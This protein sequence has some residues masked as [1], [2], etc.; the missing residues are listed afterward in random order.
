VSGGLDGRCNIKPPN[1]GSMSGR[2]FQVPLREV[3]QLNVMAVIDIS[4]ATFKLVIAC[5]AQ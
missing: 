1:L 3:L 2:K 5:T 4:S